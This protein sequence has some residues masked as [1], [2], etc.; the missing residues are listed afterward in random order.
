MLS[1]HKAGEAAH[2]RAPCLLSSP[3]AVQDRYPFPAFSAQEDCAT[4]AN[5]ATDGCGNQKAQPFHFL[6]IHRAAHHA[7]NQM[8]G[9]AC[10]WGKVDWDAAGQGQNEQAIV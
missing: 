3:F 4:A 10:H 9:D 8:P 2:A 1:W 5:A 7:T 6:S